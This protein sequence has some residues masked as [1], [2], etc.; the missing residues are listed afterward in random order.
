MRFSMQ[1]SWAVLMSCAMF[2]LAVCPRDAAAQA[3]V[4][5][6]SELRTNARVVSQTR[7]SAVADIERV[8]SLPAAREAL[9]KARVNEDQVRKAVSLL[10]DEELTRLAER[11]RAAEQDVQGDQDCGREADGQPADVERGVELVA[12]QI[13]ECGGEVVA[14][15]GCP[16]PA[17]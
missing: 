15:H 13:A 4:V 9:Q 10:S 11:S 17:M 14:E 16:M 5:P 12:A 8:L 3:H 7:A 6:S 1:R 2:L